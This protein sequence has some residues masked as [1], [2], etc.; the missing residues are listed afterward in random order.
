MQGF[1]KPK[2]DAENV[3]GCVYVKGNAGTRK[4]R[5]EYSKDLFYLYFKFLSKV[6]M[7]RGRKHPSSSPSF[8]N[9]NLSHN[10]TYLQFATLFL[11]KKHSE[12]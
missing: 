7:K 10:H 8:R 1:R 5:L 4:R 6:L 11:G 12:F 3:F 9:Q 2:K